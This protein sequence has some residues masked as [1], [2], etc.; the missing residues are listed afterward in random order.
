MGE[1]EELELIGL[2]DI[3]ARER[4]EN[5]IR[6]YADTDAPARSSEKAE[7]NSCAPDRGCHKRSSRSQEGGSAGV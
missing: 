6:D 2:G 5:F 3:D 1:T 7:V 4:R